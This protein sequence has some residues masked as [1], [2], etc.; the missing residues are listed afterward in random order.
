MNLPLLL[1]SLICLLP[2]NPVF[3][4][5]NHHS[6]VTQINE[7]LAKHPNEQRLYI[8]RGVEYSNQGEYELALADFRRAQK[9]GSPQWVTFDLGV[10]YYRK[11][12]FKTARAYFDMTLND[13]P[14]YAP[15]LVYRA[16]LLRDM[17][18]DKAAI[19]DYKKYFSL[20]KK[21]NPGHYIAS[22]TL[23]ARMKDEGVLTA[24]EMLDNG[25]KQL[26]L[27]PQ[28]QRHAISLEIQQHNYRA[29]ITRLKTLKPMLGQ[30]PDWKV[31]MGELLLLDKKSK[32]ANRFF[33]LAENQL[34]NLRKTAAHS[35]LDKKIKRLKG[36]IKT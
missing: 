23:L 19:A 14:Y 13:F 29:A 11:G 36:S 7:A 1:I 8:Q 24:L 2:I 21:P 3:A 34:K 10:L 20:Q 33:T 35:Q 17:G 31:E 6:K 9:M 4:H 26:G 18:D 16:R 32:Q 30:S 12:E 22:A 5:S 25:M 15:A 28:L 27:I